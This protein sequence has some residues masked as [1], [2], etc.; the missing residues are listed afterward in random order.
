M[1][2]SNQRVEFDSVFPLDHVTTIT[3]YTAIEVWTLDDKVGSVQIPLHWALPLVTTAMPRKD[4]GGG[5]ISAQAQQD[6][7]SEGI[8]NFELPKSIVTKIAKS[9]VRFQIRLSSMLMCL[10]D[11]RK[12]EIAKGDS[13]ISG[14]RVDR[15]HQLFG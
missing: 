7:V 4:V 9:A 3:W 13:A 2:W 10:A 15:V 1:L 14:E 6:L 12:R 11:T 5:P 8:E